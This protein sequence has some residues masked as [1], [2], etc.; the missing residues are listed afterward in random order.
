MASQWSRWEI[1]MWTLLWTLA[2]ALEADRI[3]SSLS[4]AAYSLSD[5]RQ[6][7]YPLGGYISSP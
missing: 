6:G 2:Q 7:T 3:D 4:T 5:V 1:V